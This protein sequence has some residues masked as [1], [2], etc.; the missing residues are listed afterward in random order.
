MENNIFEITTRRSHMYPT[1]RGSITVQQLWNMSLTSKDDFNLDKIAQVISKEL[2]ASTEESFVKTT[3]NAKAKDLKVMLDV[4]LHIIGVKLAE[5]EA[6]TK[7]AENAVK[8]EKLLGQLEKKQDATLESMTE[9]EIK[10]EI[11]ALDDE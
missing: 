7:R 9:E 2:K 5:K 6:A 10:K 3:P 4:V 8:R 1:S 11:A